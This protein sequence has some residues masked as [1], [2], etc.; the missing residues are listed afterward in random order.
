MT[1]SKAGTIPSPL[2][3]PQATHSLSSVQN[4]KVGQS[5]QNSLEGS[6]HP[7]S[8]HAQ[9]S[10]SARRPSIEPI[11][12]GRAG[13]ITQTLETT[14]WYGRCWD[15]DAVF[16]KSARYYG[17]TSFSSVFKENALLD[18]SEDRRRHPSSWQFGQPLLGRDRPS[19]PT[20]RMDRVIKTLWN[21]PSQDTCEALMR[22]LISS[23]YTLA[24]AV[25]VK[26]TIRTLWSTFGE[27]LSVPRTP[28]KLTAVAE[29]LFRNEEKTLPPTPDDGTEWLS[30]FTGLNLRF[31]ML[32][33]MFCFFGMASHSLLDD[34][35]RIS[36]PEN[37]GRDRRQTAWRMKECAD[38]CLTMCEISETSKLSVLWHPANI[39]QC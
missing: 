1:K 12:I 2:P 20:V 22:T 7:Q 8:N 21:I 4:S 35:A 37:H 30:N 13:S 27:Q 33:M 16:P 17:P 29:A 18:N 15:K 11:D 14:D 25:L 3:N 32:G 28:E 10:P 5:P 23:Y 24:N 19:A 26:H 31:E 9:T 38:V 39:C 6:I 34:D 36:V